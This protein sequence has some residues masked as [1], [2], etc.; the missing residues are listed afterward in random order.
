MMYCILVIVALLGGA[1][2]CANPTSASAQSTAD[3]TARLRV[4]KPGEIIR[5]AWAVYR[6]VGGN[7]RR[8]AMLVLITSS[9]PTR[10]AVLHQLSW[11][12]SSGL[13]SSAWKFDGRRS[14]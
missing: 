12:V 9:D 2:A 1:A 7:G 13:I 6:D 11:I 3:P 10:S 8:F 4:A 5:P 14:A